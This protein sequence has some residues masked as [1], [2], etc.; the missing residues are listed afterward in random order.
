MFFNKLGLTITVLPDKASLPVP[1]LSQIDVPMLGTSLPII[2]NLF[3]N[4]PFSQLTVSTTIPI[5][6]ELRLDYKTTSEYI[7]TVDKPI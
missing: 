7:F 5:S 6:P 4:P 1:Q 2:I 3:N